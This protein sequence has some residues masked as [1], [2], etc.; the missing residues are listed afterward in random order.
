MVVLWL[1]WSSQKQNT[2]LMVKDKNMKRFKMIVPKKKKDLIDQ[3]PDQIQEI[4]VILNI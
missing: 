3:G 1:A 2:S 4:N